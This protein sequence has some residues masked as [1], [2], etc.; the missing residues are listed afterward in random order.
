MKSLQISKAQ[1]N[2]GFLQIVVCAVAS[3]DGSRE[4]I[5]LQDQQVTFKHG[6]SSDCPGDKYLL[7]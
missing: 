7:D 6:F 2:I 4:V 1:E 5:C 3:Q